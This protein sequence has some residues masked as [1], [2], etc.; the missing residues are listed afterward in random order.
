MATTT[1][2][3]LDARLERLAADLDG[4]C[5]ERDAINGEMTDEQY[6]D[7]R[8]KLRNLGDRERRLRAAMA[9]AQEVRDA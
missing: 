3:P 9:K 5:A 4:I 1:R 7:L 8:R 6:V 2:D